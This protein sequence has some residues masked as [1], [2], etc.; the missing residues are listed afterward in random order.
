MTPTPLPDEGRR[1]PGDAA[2]G[3]E[4]AVAL[5]ATTVEELDLLADYM[6]ALRDEDPFQNSGPSEDQAGLAAMTS[7]VTDGTLG[8][9]WVIRA[10]ERPAGYLA[11]T[12]GYSI[13]F[14]GR[15]AFVD[16]LYVAPAFRRR[17]IARE[18]LR[19][20]SEAAIDLGVRALFIEVSGA[21]E[22]AGRLYRSCGFT[23]RKYQTLY[24]RLPTA[25]A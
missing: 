3:P 8:R 19:L 11:L 18:A 22:A 20:A 16:E 13:E 15:T 4:A 9:C 2:I 1:A 24:K 6:R 12:F 5:A 17:G 7:L 25:T 14:G 23:A 21:N 10:R